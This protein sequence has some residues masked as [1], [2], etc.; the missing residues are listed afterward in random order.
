MT[1]W[2]IIG[3]YAKV[4][5]LRNS[6]SAVEM[7]LGFGDVIS[8]VKLARVGVWAVSNDAQEI[9]QLVELE[10]DLLSELGK[11]KKDADAWLA[12]QNPALIA[13]AETRKKVNETLAK[14]AS[15]ND[16]LSVVGLMGDTEK[17]EVEDTI[18]TLRTRNHYSY[19][20]EKLQKIFESLA[21][22]MSQN[23]EPSDDGSPRVNI[24]M[25]SPAENP[26]AV[27]EPKSAL[28]KSPLQSPPPKFAG[29]KADGNGHHIGHDGIDLRESFD[30]PSE[31]EELGARP[32]A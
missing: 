28:S 25:S 16:V 31:V 13:M 6:L 24:P 11:A 2:P 10:A 32:M 23:I 1:K 18:R 26:A 30:R 15:H 3:R 5:L 20:S 8:E 22:R 21:L 7:A 27:E 12:K 14:L 29:Q 19:G 4:L 9:S 17:I